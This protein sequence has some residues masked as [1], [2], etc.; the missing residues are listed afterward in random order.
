MEVREI[1]EERFIEC[2]AIDFPNFKI[3]K[4]NLTHPTSHFVTSFYSLILHNAIELKDPDEI[5]NLTEDQR[6]YISSYH[7]EAVS[8]S[9]HV[10]IHNL[11][12]TI[13][14]VF[15]HLSENGSEFVFSDI[16][17]PE[18]TP[19][20]SFVF[21]ALM[22][23]FYWYS[24]DFTHDLE[25]DITASL[26]KIQN[27]RDLKEEKEKYISQLRELEFQRCQ[28]AELYKE[29]KKLAKKNAEVNEE[30]EMIMKELLTD[31][32]VI[33]KNVEKV[34]IEQEKLQTELIKHQN[35][36][37]YYESLIVSNE[38]QVRDIY[39]RHIIQK[40]ECVKKMKLLEEKVKATS[41]TVT[42]SSKVLELQQKLNQLLKAD[43]D[44]KTFRGF[45]DLHRH[46]L[47]QTEERNKVSNE[48]VLLDKKLQEAQ[49][50]LIKLKNDNAKL[51]MEEQEI[52]TGSKDAVS[53]RK[54]RLEKLEKTHSQLLIKLSK[55]SE[56]IE[57]IIASTTDLQPKS[58][59]V[60][61]QINSIDTMHKEKYSKYINEMKNI[62]EL[63]DESFGSGRKDLSNL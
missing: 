25:G 29:K 52:L 12:T 42:K 41:N 3:T 30:K 20:R 13:K 45:Q 43:S 60:E 47:N 36:I 18:N 31:E 27:F 22:L 51:N 4:S 5:W 17:F 37:N 16:L 63:L 7:P 15:N 40:D 10:W 24:I 48:K 50:A 49:E 62:F 35:E 14:Y 59:K 39:E 61:I 28:Y 2:M 32:E 34:E 56:N 9:Q 6:S 46:F 38:H 23:N 44:S 19:R 55:D 54:K 11:H 57:Q 1:T 33:Q 53:E 26:E 58:T 21:M 8:F